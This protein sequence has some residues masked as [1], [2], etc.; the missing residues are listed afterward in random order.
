[1][2]TPALTPLEWISTKNH[3][4]KGIAG[5]TDTRIE[6][7][8]QV[9][10]MAKS[11]GKS[12]SNKPRKP[13]DGFPLFAHATKRWAKKIRGKLHYFGPWND[14]DA[15]L[16]KYLEQRDDLHA[17][18]RPRNE[19]NDPTIRDLCNRYLTSKTHLLETK[20]ITKR[21]FQGY[22]STCSKIIDA[23]GRDRILDDL[24]PTD[25][26]ELR[27]GLSKTLG[28]VALGNEIQR[29]RMVFKYA[30]DQGLIEKPTRFGQGFKKPSRK[31]LR[32]QRQQNGKRMFEANELRLI[33]DSTRQ[34]LN[35]MVLLGIN[36]G[37]GQSDL[38]QLPLSC[39][40][41]EN[42]WVDFPRPKTG[43]ERRCPLWLETVQAIREAINIRPKPKSELDSDRLYI[44]KYGHRWV[45][46]NKSGTPDDAIGKEFAKLLRSLELKR[47]GVSFY[48]LRHTFETIG[49]ESLDQ[50]AVDHIMGHARD[51]MA[52]LYRERISDKR[53]IAV[54]NTIRDWLFPGDA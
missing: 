28:P 52:S 46:T 38:S 16:K 3:S 51:D 36:C 14:P 42:G 17:G 34:P 13:Y 26:E 27:T 19:T 25:F 20:E 37:F 18:R 31:V 48:A 4:P 5:V 53:L 35:S 10:A 6:I 49:G 32:Q 43:V 11:T 30:Y 54:T 23:F 33:I 47:P 2:L 1:M 50:V 21:T 44:T 24:Q 8:I 15:A 7:E 9:T 12:P 45:K 41:L 40:D 39:I 29:V 22:H